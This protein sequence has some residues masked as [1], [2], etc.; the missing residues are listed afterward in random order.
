MVNISHRLEREH[1]D[2]DRERE[3]LENGFEER[4]MLR[5]FIHKVQAG[6]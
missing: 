5:C 6:L 4:G 1:F 2:C 3:K